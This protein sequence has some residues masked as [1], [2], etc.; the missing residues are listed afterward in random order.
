MG[1][2][3]ELATSFEEDVINQLEV[4]D[5]KLDELLRLLT[6]KRDEPPSDD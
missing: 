3:K 5:E 6:E 1:R 2:M 4:L